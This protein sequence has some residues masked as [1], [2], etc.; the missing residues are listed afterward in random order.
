[1]ETHLL[2]K[3]MQMRVYS[4]LFYFIYWNVKNFDNDAKNLH[5]LIVVQL[6]K[7]VKMIDLSI[8]KEVTLSISQKSFLDSPVMVYELKLHN[9][10]L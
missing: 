8:V 6:D 10:Y 5:F 1:M 9:N 2:T 4:P 3:I 7:S